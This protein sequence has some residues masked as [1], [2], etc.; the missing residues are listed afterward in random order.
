MPLCK[1]CQTDVTIAVT[2][3]SICPA[4]GRPFELSEDDWD[5]DEFAL[6]EF[7]LDDGDSPEDTA[8]EGDDL[9]VGEATEA[10]DAAAAGGT[11]P[12]PD[13]PTPPT[14]SDNLAGR[15][16]AVD[17][18]HV[19]GGKFAKDDG[20][21]EDSWDDVDDVALGAS[22]DSGDS[23]AADDDDEA[24]AGPGDVTAPLAN[25]GAMAGESTDFELAEDTNSG[26]GDDEPGLA[27]PG[28]AA[29][30]SDTDR[31]NPDVTIAFAG[32]GTDAAPQ[33]G[34]QTGAEPDEGSGTARPGEPAMLDS[35][36]PPSGSSSSAGSSA[37]QSG[38]L[39]AGLSGS[40][41]PSAGASGTR[42]EGIDS[43]D[44]R[45]SGTLA[46]DGDSDRRSDRIETPEPRQVT[47]LESGQTMPRGPLGDDQA[48]QSLRPGD[49][50]VVGPEN[51][52]L[53][54]YRLGKD[55]TRGPNDFLFEG[56]SFKGGMGVVHSTRQ[57]SLDRR[58]AVKQVKAEMSAN[59]ADRNKFISEAVIT[60]QLEHPNIIPVHDLGLASDGLPFYSMKFVEGDEWEKQLKT[61]G[62]EENLSIL[63]QV[64][65]A[66]A[67]AHSRDI[68]HRDLKP[69]NVMLG[70]YGEVLVMDWGLAARLD[71]SDIPP[72]GTPV[73]MPP[74]TAL[75]YLDY[76]KGRIGGKK[77]T[78]RR[79]PPGT[80]SDIYLLG[81]L[82]FKIVTGRAPHK[83]KTTFECLKAAA[84]NEIVKTSRR[85]ELLDI[86]YKALKTDPGERHRD[87]AEFIDEIR[88][89]QAHAQ[90]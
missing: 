70:G 41:Q 65:Q 77:S 46:I 26:P 55:E 79:V 20:D 1:H 88:A 25:A 11:T 38:T 50:H 75:Q 51:V 76:T 4:C 84:R 57:R 35:D 68:I 39:P 16:A 89:Y 43:G 19:F 31:V 83:G 15:E 37:G 54:A 49:T 53:R 64:S 27:G 18:T 13:A 24:T 74:E 33:A 47:G 17:M 85:G 23:D 45:D 72:S 30:G 61:L 90:S 34:L 52:R 73:Y 60:G 3:G 82:L 80:Y 56:K 9:G 81:G 10:F 8:Q 87:V 66:I 69:S 36:R 28:A 62:E 63:I 67:F 71:G 58:V 86:A 7:A 78:T 2:S 29:Q 21:N 12:E 48:S 42:N 14:D 59:E 44:G 22:S 32:D 6:D 40:G 5:V